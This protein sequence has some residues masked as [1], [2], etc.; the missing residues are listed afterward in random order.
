MVKEG[1][2]ERE[3]GREIGVRERVYTPPSLRIGDSNISSRNRGRY[4]WREASSTPVFNTAV[5]YIQNGGGHWMRQSGC[6]LLP[7]NRSGCG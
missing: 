5:S 4:G 2:R 3:G 7:Q 6:A 1:G